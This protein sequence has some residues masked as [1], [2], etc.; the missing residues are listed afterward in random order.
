MKFSYEVYQMI[1]YGS[2]PLL[3]F[4]IFMLSLNSIWIF[5]F[6]SL[7]NFHSAFFRLKGSRERK[8]TN[9][10][11]DNFFLFPHDYNWEGASCVTPIHSSVYWSDHL[12]TCRVLL[13]KFSSQNLLV[14]QDISTYTKGVFCMWNIYNSCFLRVFF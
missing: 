11:N 13:L 2:Y 7:L 14:L 9:D 6:D 5:S 4:E 1:L 8:R 3:K 12:F 10:Q